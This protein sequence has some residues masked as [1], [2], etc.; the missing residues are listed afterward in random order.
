[1]KA[2]VCR[3]S[4]YVIRAQDV[5]PNVFLEGRHEWDHGRVIVT[6]TNVFLL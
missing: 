1:M 6:V 2:D 3:S 5:G 4:K